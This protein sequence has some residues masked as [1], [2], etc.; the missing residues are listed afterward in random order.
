MEN[1]H[2]SMPANKL[3]SDVFHSGT[4]SGTQALPHSHTHTRT[5]THTLVLYPSS[6]S[7]LCLGESK[8]DQ[9]LSG[10]QVIDFCQPEGD[11]PKVDTFKQP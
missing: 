2:R 6:T 3:I 5:Y 9:N 7:S 8:S 11:T 10:Y 1:Q 4:T